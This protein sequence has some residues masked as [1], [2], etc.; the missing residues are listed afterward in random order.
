MTF[1]RIICGFLVAVTVERASLQAQEADGG[2]GVRKATQTLFS[3]QS[4][5]VPL[6]FRSAEA[7]ENPS[8]LAACENALT[9][10][11]S[12]LGL[13]TWNSSR[14]IV[15][16]DA[17]ASRPTWVEAFPRQVS[18]VEKEWVF[19]IRGQGEWASAEE[20]LY[21]TL[22][23]CLLQSQMLDDKTSLPESSFPDP[24]FWLSE[25]LTQILM[26]SRRQD[27]AAAVW[28]FSL[29]KKIPPLDAVQKWT[30]LSEDGIRR[31]W[32]QTF[33]FW[34]ATQATRTVAD[35]KTLQGYLSTYLKN[36]QK[37]YWT[38]EP[39]NEECLKTGSPGIRLAAIRGPFA[40]GDLSF[41]EISR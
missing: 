11:A 14:F 20:N 7:V 32:Q 13:N 36:G 3:I 31:S 39:F 29:A 35:K 26:E 41:R 30:D 37:R 40:G 25:G 8:R 9:L 4:E 16:W 21:R 18:R 38:M 33:V 23:T 6:T 19:T 28:R 12:R 22:A 1:G 5:K 15:I 27:F 10:L 34:L 17:Q 2:G 24:P